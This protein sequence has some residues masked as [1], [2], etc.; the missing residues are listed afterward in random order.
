MPSAKDKIAAAA[1]PALKRRSRRPNLRSCQSVSTN[2]SQLTA[3]T[4]SFTLSAP[5]ISMHAARNASS[6]L[7]PPRILSFT[8]AARYP[9]NSSSISRSTCS[10]RNNPR[11]PLARLL[12]NGMDNLLRLRFEDSRNGSRLSCPFARFALELFSAEYRQR[13]VLRAPVVLR[14]PPFALEP[15]RPFEPA[16]C[17]KERPWVHLKHAFADL[18]D[19]KSNAVAVHGFQ[20]QR[21]QDEHVQRALHQSTRFLRH[22]S[23]S[24]RLSRGGAPLRAHR[25]FAH[26]FRGTIR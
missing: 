9:R 3:R 6:R 4:C 8:A 11:R 25:S 1:K 26:P 13:V 21:F 18:P 12:S 7:I 16:E 10:L 22:E 24:S 2:D 19:A 14:R 15:A 17:R 23:R 20:P 5:P